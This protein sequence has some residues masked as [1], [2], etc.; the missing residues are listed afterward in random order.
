MSISPYKPAQTLTLAPRSRHVVWIPEDDVVGI[1]V[2]HVIETEFGQRAQPTSLIILSTESAYVKWVLHKHCTYLSVRQYASRFRVPHRLVANYATSRLGRALGVNDGRLPDCVS[3]DVWRPLWLGR[4][5]PE[6]I[7]MQEIKAYIIRFGAQLLSNLT[8]HFSTN[9]SRAAVRMTI[10]KM[11]ERGELRKEGRRRHA[12]I[13]LGEK[14]GLD[15]LPE[16]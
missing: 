7:R 5:R 6:E 16:S 14:L 4:Q 3:P 13:L 12:V 9:V 2:D 8:F 10:N 1:L 15:R 11:I